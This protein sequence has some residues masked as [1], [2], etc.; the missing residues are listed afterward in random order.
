MS[1]LGRHFGG[2]REAR[3]SDNVEAM[4]TQLLPHISDVF[5]TSLHDSDDEQVLEPITFQ[6]GDDAR[7][8]LLEALVRDFGRAL[9]YYRISH[10][11]Q[12]FNL[13]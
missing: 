1:R 7:R 13:E 8:D 10:V 4:I 2:V 12:E 6:D 5:S 9:H 3:R 11:E